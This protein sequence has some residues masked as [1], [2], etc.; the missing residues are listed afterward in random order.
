M[1]LKTLQFDKRSTRFL[2]R[3]LYI[4]LLLSFNGCVSYDVKI[5]GESL[6]LAE[7]HPGKLCFD[8]IVK[9]KVVVRSTYLMGKTGSKIYK[10]GIDY[11]VDFERGEIARTANSTIPN[12]AKHPLYGEKSFDHTKFP[13]F[14]NHSY[15]VWVDYT[16]SSH[17]S[18]A[19]ANNQA[20]YLI[21]TK[22]KLEKG[23]PLSIVSY[24]NSI[25]AGGEASET[26]LRFQ[27]RYVRYLETRF[28]KAQISLEDVSISG[29]MSQHGIEKWDAYIGKTSPDL[30]L[31]GWGMND[32]NKG[33]NAPEQYKSYLVQLV[34]M[35]QEKKNAEVIIFSAFPPNK[36]WFYSSKNMEAFALAAKQAALEANCAYADVYSTWARVLKRKD[37]SSLL[38]N[39]INHPND[40]GHWL[41]LQAFKAMT[42]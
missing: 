6:V 5:K 2:L 3:L 41:Y 32:H 26:A 31:L 35:I 4:S 13:N 33:A 17:V 12:Y 30:V 29:H 24:G 10:E 40:F 37:Q 20:L 21:K 23:E 28:P 16:T 22:E 34:R 8:L 42:F 1:K 19:A 25:T 39:N 9:G 18:L 15:F 14:E 36:E 27:Y 38:G 7:N 11:T